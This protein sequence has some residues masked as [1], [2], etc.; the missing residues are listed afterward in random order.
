LDTNEERGAIDAVRKMTGPNIRETF[1]ARVKRTDV[2]SRGLYKTLVLDIRRVGSEKVF[3]AHQWLTTT[4]NPNVFAGEKIQFE[5]NWYIWEP[6]NSKEGVVLN[7][8]NKFEVLKDV[9]QES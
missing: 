4:E 5:A 6:D 9:F 1:T 7:Y 2:D 8:P 3:K